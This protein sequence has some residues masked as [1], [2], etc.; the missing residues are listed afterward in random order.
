M[1]MLRK[2]KV[3][4]KDNLIRRGWQGDISCVFYGDFETVN[5]LFVS[6]NFAKIIWNWIARYNSFTFEGAVLDDIWLIDC[7]IPLKDKLL[8]ELIRSAICWVIW[9]ERNKVIFLGSAISSMRTLDLRIIYLCT[10][11]CTARQ[12][13]Q[14][15]NLTLLFPQW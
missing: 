15:L 10:F 1:W 11:W 5:H 12:T 14:M 3:L 7:C 13:S 2:N 4:T 9:L 6:Y 8:V